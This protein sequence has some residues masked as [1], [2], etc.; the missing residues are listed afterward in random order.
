MHAFT[1]LHIYSFTFLT[2]YFFLLSRKQHLARPDMPAHFDI[3]RANV[4]AAPAFYTRI[5]IIT[6]RHIEKVMFHC[7]SYL[8]R[9]Q[10]LRA[11]LQT[12]AA[13]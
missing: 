7:V 8:R 10:I 1:H 6:F 12:P 5:N 9:I 2:R 13:P 4:T 11:Y 3:R